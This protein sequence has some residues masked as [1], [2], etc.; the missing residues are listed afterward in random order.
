MAPHDAR[1]DEELGGTRSPDNYISFPEEGEFFKNTK[2]ILPWGPSG[3]YATERRII[4]SIFVEALFRK[5]SV[6]RPERLGD[7]HFMTRSLGLDG[8]L[9]FMDDALQ[10][11]LDEG[12]LRLGEDNADVFPPSE[13]QDLYE[14]ADR[15]VTQLRDRPELEVTPDSWEWLEG[16]EQSARAYTTKELEIDWIHQ[17]TMRTLTEKTGD[18]QHYIA[19]AWLV[20][21][22]ATALER[23][24]ATDTWPCSLSNNP[25]YESY[26][27]D[28]TFLLKTFL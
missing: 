13:V 7:P 26:L 20:G 23:A 21:P 1:W 12:L 18:L 11:L 27:E 9:N 15:L 22:R 2:D 10:L 14:G 25:Y 5:V 19:L 8:N 6:D 3:A 17:L 24:A 16:Y 4:P 28:R